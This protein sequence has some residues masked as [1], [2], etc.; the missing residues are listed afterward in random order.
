M[1]GTPRIQCVQP[2]YFRLLHP[3]HVEAYVGLVVDKST[4]ALG[5]FG[6]D[7]ES[8]GGPEME[9]LFR[10]QAMWSLS[11]LGQAADALTAAVWVAMVALIV[12]IILKRP[13]ASDAGLNG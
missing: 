8:I 4:E 7:V 13:P 9:S 10:E 12:S 3:E 1:V 6:L 11:P 5:V 2:L